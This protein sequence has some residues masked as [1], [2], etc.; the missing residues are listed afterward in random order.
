MFSV[1]AA[2]LSLLPM[3]PSQIQLNNLRLDAS[4]LTVPT[5]R[6]DP[7][8]LRAPSHWD[9]AFISRFMV[10]FGPISS[11]FDFVTFALIAGPL[12]AGPT[13]LRAGRFAESLATQTLV[14]FAIRTRRSTSTRSR[15]SRPLLSAALATVL[16]GAL[17]PMSPLANLLDF[18]HLPLRFFLARAAMAAG[19][20]VL[21]ELAKRLFFA[22]PEGRLPH[23]PRD[24]RHRRR[25]HRPAA[26]FS[27]GG[28]LPR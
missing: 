14:I 21:M 19:Y 6:V 17:L 25:V 13:L 24:D 12:H 22:D 4:Q 11:M 23:L 3:L 15:P 5:D 9:T 27:V 18:A 20:L 10:F 1:A 8:Q 26:R 7:E 28:R 2:V 16:V